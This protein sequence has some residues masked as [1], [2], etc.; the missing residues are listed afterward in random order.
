MA[1]KRLNDTAALT[2]APVQEHQHVSISVRKIENGHLVN[3]TRCGPGGEYE[4][5]EYF[6]KDPP[7]IEAIV[8]SRNP[9]TKGSL[10]DA[11]SYLK[12]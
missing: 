12:D 4:N 7:K 10:A 1:K 8:K 2:A 5:H 3:E 6:A 9:G 11:T